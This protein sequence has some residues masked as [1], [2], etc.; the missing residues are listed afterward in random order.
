[1][2]PRTKLQVQV[3]ALSQAL[4]DLTI[5]QKAWAFK[6]CLK[7]IAFRTKKSLSCLDCG[8]VWV[9]PPVSKKLLS[10]LHTSCECPSCEV[11]LEIQDSRNKKKFEQ[12][13]II[14]ALIDVVDGFQ[15]TRFFELN[16]YHKAGQ[17]AKQY[18]WEVV[19]HWFVPNGKTTIVARMAPFGYNGGFTGDLEIRPGGVCANI[20]YV[21]DKYNIYA[22]YTYPNVKCLPIYKRNGFTTKLKDIYPYSLFTKLLTDTKVETLLKS[23]Q[24]KLLSERLHSK[25]HLIERY[26]SSIKICIRQN[27]LVKDAGVWL[28]YLE[29]L[30]FFNKDLR[31]SKYVCPKNLHDA[32]NKLVAK[33]RQ[34]QKLKEAEK[35]RKQIA[36]AEP[37]YQKEKGHFFGLVF[38]K[39]D[40]TIKVLESVR[41]FMEEGD[42]H[43][44]C[45]FT[46]RYYKEKD[47][48]CFS[49]KIKGASV[50]TVEV[51]LKTMKIVQS[52]G[53]QNRATSFHDRIVELVNAN[54]PLI[55]KRMEPKKA[56]TKASKQQGMAA[57][58]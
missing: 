18:L 25:S 23:K 9:G 30:S 45:V 34:F 1:M 42:I 3:L 50:E 31:S 19:Q 27:Y 22:D 53:M 54:I 46:N 16:S 10:R 55:K 44:H 15:T 26:W 17:P 57:V 58:A 32:H 56:K 43:K 41:E 8:H 21:A 6:N 2:K 24:F 12:R 47:S 36:E 4:A 13:H 14:I 48:L 39:G 20:G 40:L 35:M 52:R 51:S 49:A 37:T 5:D 33:K 28:D 11:R 38:T 29:L 7:H